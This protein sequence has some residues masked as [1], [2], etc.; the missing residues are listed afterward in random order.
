MD[1]GCCVLTT[2][3][4]N[5]IWVCPGVALNHIPGVLGPGINP[6]KQAEM[7]DNDNE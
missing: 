1:Y 6:T 3:A 4:L 2:N 5:E 7:R